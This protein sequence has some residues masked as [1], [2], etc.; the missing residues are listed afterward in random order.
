MRILTLA[1][2]EEWPL[3]V[4]GLRFAMAIA[5]ATKGGDAD[6][7]NPDSAL[8]WATLIIVRIADQRPDP[9]LTD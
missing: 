6:Q 4:R 1:S 3:S 9:F 5:G 7:A 8:R 2:F